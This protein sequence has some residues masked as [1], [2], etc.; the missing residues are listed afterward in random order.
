MT[1]I[2]TFLKHFEGK[3]YETESDNFC[4]ISNISQI[5]IF[6][7]LWWQSV[8]YPVRPATDPARPATDPA[9]PSA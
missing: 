7:Q 1:S 2:R 5:L 6:K 3:D 8:T 9:P 4:F